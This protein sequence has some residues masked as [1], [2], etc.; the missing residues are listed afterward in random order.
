MTGSPR[1]VTRA[2]LQRLQGLT[3]GRERRETG[4]CLVE[5]ATLLGEALAAGCVP[6]LV[7]VEEALIEDRSVRAARAAGAEVVT[8]DERSAA[9]VSDREQARGLLAVVPVPATWDGSSGVPATGPVLV[10]A[11]CGL[12]D[13]GNVG[14][15]LRS[16]RAFGATAV[17][18]MAGTADAFG[19][20]VVRASAGAVF[21]LALRAAQGAGGEVDLGA[22]ASAHELQPARGVQPAARDRPARPGTAGAAAT[23]PPRCLLLLGH[24]TRGVP[25]L[26][27][28]TAVSVRHE[29]GVESLNVAMAGS[30]LLSRWYEQHMGPAA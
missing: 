21:G 8:I 15:L 24:E 1:P 28:T 5:G 17:V 25:E 14:T 30:I 22:L 7:A 18:T 16:A 13:P 12:Q 2:E 19:P 6:E 27:G 10:V 9:R 23:P 3:R 4:C 11:L 29:P 20:K 26:A